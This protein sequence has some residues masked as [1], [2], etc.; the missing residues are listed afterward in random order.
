[1]LMLL[2]E[3]LAELFMLA[4][5]VLFSIISKGVR[6]RE[7]EKAGERRTQVPLQCVVT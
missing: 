4:A 3:V 1:M 7:G 6:E 2:M 5:F